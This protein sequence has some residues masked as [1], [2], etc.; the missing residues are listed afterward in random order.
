MLASKFSFAEMGWSGNTVKV[1]LNRRF[2]KAAVAA[3]D[4]SVGITRFW[5]PF[6]V[7]GKDAAS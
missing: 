3:G 1:G 4:T 6:V 7:V 5:A 2:H